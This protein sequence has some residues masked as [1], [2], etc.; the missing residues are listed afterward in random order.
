MLVTVD[1]MMTL[2][3][4]VLFAYSPALIFVTPYGICRVVM[5]EQPLKADA[6]KLIAFV[7]DDLTVFS[8]VQSL[9]A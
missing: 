2:V 5:F 6:A 4:F 3:R 8:W 7:T 9:N 1:G